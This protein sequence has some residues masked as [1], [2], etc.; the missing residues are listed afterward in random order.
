MKKTWIT[1]ECRELNLDKTMAGQ[2]KDEKETSQVDCVPEDLG[3]GNFIEEY[4]PYRCNL[5]S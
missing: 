5:A 2:V 4:Y 3:D 1:P